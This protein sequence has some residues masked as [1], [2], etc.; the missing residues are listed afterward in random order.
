MGYGDSDTHILKCMYIHT[1]TRRLK[2]LDGAGR[3]GDMRNTY[4][5]TAGVMNVLLLDSKIIYR[6]EDGKLIEKGMKM[7]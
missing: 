5:H 3:G 6:G 4:I 7:E 1:R 2:G